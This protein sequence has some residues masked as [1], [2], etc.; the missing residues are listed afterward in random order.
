MKTTLEEKIF[1]WAHENDVRLHVDKFEP[2]F[3]A[4]NQYVA[5]IIGED[6]DPFIPSGGG[7]GHSAWIEER[8]ELRAEQ[9]NR[10]GL[11]PEKPDGV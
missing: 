2:I 4:I 10:A 8:N 11:T 6:E 1:K 5:E 7:D 9:R 3:E